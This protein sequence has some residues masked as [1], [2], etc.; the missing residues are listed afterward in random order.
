[1]D[2]GQDTKVACVDNGLRTVVKTTLFVPRAPP[3]QSPTGTVRGSDR[4]YLAHG[5]TH[6]AA[7]P[8]E[9]RILKPIPARSISPRIS[10]GGRPRA[11]KWES[12]HHLVGARPGIIRRHGGEVRPI[13]A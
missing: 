7:G 5:S 6:G 3:F 1:M 13:L 11:G 10:F 2:S 4:M 8:I 12:F 9:L